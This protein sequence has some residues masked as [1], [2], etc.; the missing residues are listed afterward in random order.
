M[1]EEIILNK[2]K[3]YVFSNYQFTNLIWINNLY[4]YDIIL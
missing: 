4:E 3:K 1:T 2:L